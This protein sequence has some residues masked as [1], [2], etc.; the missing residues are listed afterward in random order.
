MLERNYELLPL[1]ALSSVYS[2]KYCSMVT[3]EITICVWEWNCLLALSLG[4]I[5]GFNVYLCLIL[6]TEK[7]PVYFNKLYSYKIHVQ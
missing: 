4:T 6:V 7:A 2:C 3:E 5:I 1:Y